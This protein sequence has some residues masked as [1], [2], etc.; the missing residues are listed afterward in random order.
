M[1]GRDR[2]T[3]MGPP[4]EGERSAAATA[5]LNKHV[6]IYFSHNILDKIYIVSS[7]KTKSVT[8]NVCRGQSTVPMWGLCRRVRECAFGGL[9]RPWLRVC[10]C[11]QMFL[12]APCREAKK[13]KNPKCISFLIALSSPP[14]PHFLFPSHPV[15]GNSKPCAAPSPSHVQRHL[16]STVDAASPLALAV[17]D[18]SS[19]KCWCS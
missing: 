12:V 3:N 11:A 8:G 18:N 16:P 2:E 6:F 4:K 1:V 15:T 14:S 7:L 5:C 9:E 10:Q 17:P 13:S 19:Y